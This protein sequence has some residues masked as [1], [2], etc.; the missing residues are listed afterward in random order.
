MWQRGRRGVVREQPEAIAVFD[1]PQASEAVPHAGSGDL[2]VVGD[3]GR[4]DGRDRGEVGQLAA[5]VEFDVV[6]RAGCGVKGG[7]KTG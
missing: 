1:P 5:P 3:V 4:E 6:G 2:D 7:G